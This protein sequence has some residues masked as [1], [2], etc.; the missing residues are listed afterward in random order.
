MN[1]VPV[2]LCV[3]KYTYLNLIAA[4]ALT[5][6]PFSFCMA[7]PPPDF[8]LEEASYQLFHHFDE[9]HQVAVWEHIPFAAAVQKDDFWGHRT[10]LVSFIYFSPY[11]EAGKQKYFLLTK[12]VPV[13]E[14]F[15]CHACLPL[16]SA[17]VFV[18]KNNRF[19]LESKNL[20]L[21]YAGEYA[22]S[23]T[24]KWVNLPAGKHGLAL[25]FRHYGDDAEKTKNVL[26]YSSGSIMHYRIIKAAATL[27]SSE[28]SAL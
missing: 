7:A 27:R 1:E 14:P 8:T 25:T 28:A 10:G 15:E 9:E 23:P 5:I 24:V 4:L 21:M 19:I 26:V 3:M 2:Y 13:G 6:L 18:K 22:E 20:F 12:A 11:T 16:L 17:A